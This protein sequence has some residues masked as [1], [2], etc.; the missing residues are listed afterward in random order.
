MAPRKSAAATTEGAVLSIPRPDIRETRIAIV[1]VSPAISNKFSQKSRMMILAKQFQLPEAYKPLEAKDPVA[2]FEACIHW[3]R[4]R[5][6]EPYC[7]MPGSSFKA[8]LVAA[9]R[10]TGGKLEM[11]KAKQLFHV[12]PHMIRIH[13]DD[14][15]MCE[16]VVRNQTGVI[17]IRFRAMFV[18]WSAIIP[19]RYHA[20]SISEQVLV[21]L[22]M[23]AGFGCGIGD[24]RTAAPK[25]N[26]GQLGQWRVA[27]GNEPV[28]EEHTTFCRANP[29]PWEEVEQYGVVHPDKVAYYAQFARRPDAE[30]SDDE[31]AQ[32]KKKTSRKTKKAPATREAA[33]EVLQGLATA[34]EVAE[35]DAIQNGQVDDEE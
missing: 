17:D 4:G 5:D 22:A 11:T 8:S 26:N 35:M 24:W 3:V 15:V 9:C 16:H 34:D 33:L 21:S 28:G 1:G 29:L 20:G 2:N 13:G 32:P 23:L 7:A 30:T 12:I 14:P 27:E 10:M 19:I 25:S 6:G 31:A 18:R